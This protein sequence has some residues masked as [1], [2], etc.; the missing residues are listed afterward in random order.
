[1]ITHCVYS[2]NK[3]IQE[4]V[5]GLEVSIAEALISGVIKDTSTTTP[6]NEMTDT[7]QVGNYISEP[8]DIALEARRMGDYFN[9]LAQ[10]VATGAS[11]EV[12]E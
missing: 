11:V 7:D 5:P 10:P 8:I 12:K 2:K 3:D 1:M 4:T 6:Y 9:N